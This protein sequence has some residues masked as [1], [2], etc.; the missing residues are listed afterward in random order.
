MRPLPM[1]VEVRDTVRR[2][3]I[4]VHVE[5]RSLKEAVALGRYLLEHGGRTPMKFL[6]KQHLAECDTC[7]RLEAKRLIRTHEQATSA[8]KKVPTVQART[9]REVVDVLKQAVKETRSPAV[10]TFL[11]LY[12]PAVERTQ[13]A[14]TTFRSLYRR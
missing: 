3:L 10:Q 13:D 12:K 11:D 2:P 4:K 6:Y 8:L 7:Q 14:V 1:R 5:K 9:I